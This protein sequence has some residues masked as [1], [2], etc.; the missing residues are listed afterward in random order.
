MSCYWHI[1]H[2]NLWSW[3]TVIITLI[4]T[5][6]T[7]FHSATY[8]SVHP[9]CILFLSSCISCCVL[10]IFQLRSMLTT[11]DF[12]ADYTNKTSH[13]AVPTTYLPNTLP[14]P[15]LPWIN[16]IYLGQVACPSIGDLIAIFGISKGTWQI[17]LA[18][19]VFSKGSATTYLLFC[20]C[21]S[22]ILFPRGYIRSSVVKHSVRYNN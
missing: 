18:L 9:S 15:S 14:A 8:P 13:P 20:V 19:S 10:Y 21:D 6:L 11:M 7:L 5:W 17:H 22:F 16:N 4:Y 1:K 3:P 2:C 12:C